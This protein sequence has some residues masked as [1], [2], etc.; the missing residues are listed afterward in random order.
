MSKEDAVA[1]VNSLKEKPILGL[2]HNDA[3]DIIK[4]KILL[5]KMLMQNLATNEK[6]LNANIRLLRTDM[7]I[8]KKKRLCLEELNGLLEAQLLSF[9]DIRQRQCAKKHLEYLKLDVPDDKYTRL[10]KLS[11]KYKNQILELY[12]KVTTFKN[13]IPKEVDIENY[14]FVIRNEDNDIQEVQP[15]TDAPGDAAP[16][17]AAPESES[18]DDPDDLKTSDA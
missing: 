13:L 10:L 3:M 1:L 17:D 2:P 15:Y 6:L 14:T 16:G 18:D 5:N 8:S 11:E 9:H 7:K 12:N 4:R